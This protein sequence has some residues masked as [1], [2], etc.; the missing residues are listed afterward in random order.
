MVGVPEVA[1]ELIR[2]GA[3]VNRVNGEG[4]TPLDAALSSG[5]VR[6]AQVLIRAGGS[7]AWASRWRH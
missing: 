5:N 1:V 4:N 6:V 7:P 2:A 3:D